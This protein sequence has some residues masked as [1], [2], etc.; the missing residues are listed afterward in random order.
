MSWRNIYVVLRKEIVDSV[1]DRRTLIS[2]IVAPI[3][4]M[5]VLVYGLG[6][7]Q[8]RLLRRAQQEVPKVMILGGERSPKV[9]GAFHSL[10]TIEVLPASGD[11]AKQIVDKRIRAAV[12]IPAD[13][14]AALERVESPLV[15]IYYYEGEMLSGLAVQR[16]QLFFQ[17]LRNKT[18]QERLAARSLPATLLIP[19]EVKPKNVAPPEKVS[20][21]A[22]GGVIAYMIIVFCL[23]GAMYPAM[24]LTAGEKERGTIE[25][26]LCS[27][28]ARRD[29]VLGKFFTVLAASLVTAGLSFGSLLATFRL[30]RQMKP[31]A[32]G[33]MA[34]QLPMQFD[35]GRLLA[36][37]AMLLPVAVMFSAALLAVSMLA[38][39]YKEAQT[40]LTPLLLVAVLP[41]MLAMMPG[42][43]LN[44][45]LALVPVLN[46][47]LLSKEIFTGTSPWRY[48]LLVSVS[49]CVYAAAALWGTAKLFE[50]EDV[51]FRI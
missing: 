31:G 6:T 12:E 2:M 9:I 11:Y 38:K 19:F 1:R 22:L 50:R 13:F 51:L 8:T 25:T 40:Y 36:V 16:L 21:A 44:A 35:L 46:T 14:D 37:V 3:L 23:T 17:E 20:G 43:E 29:L 5:P 41:A 33:Q 18:V 48:V 39:S 24:D 10:K 49:S 15:Q 34:T 7:L 26:I 4:V 27:P 42:V 28:V 47:G 32:G 45:K 30:A